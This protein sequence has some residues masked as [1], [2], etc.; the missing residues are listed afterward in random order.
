MTDGANPATSGPTPRWADR[1]SPWWAKLRRAEVHIREVKQAISEYEKTTAWE[2]VREP[3]PEPH[4]TSYVLR[5]HRE[6]PSDV[7]TIVGDAVHNLRSALDAVAFE[8]ARGFVGS[9][10]TEHQEKATEF[11]ICKDP[12]EFEKWLNGGYG[13]VKRSSLYGDRERAALRCVQPFAID[14]NARALGVDVNDDADSRL[15]NDALYR[16][17]KVSVIDKHRRLPLVTLMPE[18]FVMWNAP[19]E[20]ETYHWEPVGSAP[21]LDGAAVGTFTNVG[22]LTRPVHD[23]SQELLLTLADDPGSRRDLAETLEGWLRTLHRWVLPCIMLVAEGAEPPIML[24][25]D[26]PA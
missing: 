5:V 3:G 21:Y 11:P 10:L 15:R 2:I 1:E 23:V 9:S 17:H 16:L 7:V 13:G 25:F 20:G 18:N 22:G 24:T 12:T 8:L 14:E 4:Q 6:L 19:P 26:A